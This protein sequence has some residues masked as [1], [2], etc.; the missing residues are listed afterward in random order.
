LSYVSIWKPVHDQIVQASRNAQNE[1]IGLLLGRLDTDT[2]IIEDSIT[3]EFE[4]EKHRAILTS[5]T[6]AR[7]ADDVVNGRVKGSIVGWYHSHTEGGLF[8]SDTDIQTQKNLQQFS[9][10]VTALVADSSNGETGYFRVDTRTGRQLRIPGKNV[11]VFEDP[12]EAVPLDRKEKARVLPT[13]TVEVRA[14]P[15]RPKLPSRNMILA[16]VLVALALSVSLFGLLL[17][18]GFPTVPGLAIGHDPVLTGTIGAPIEIKA[19]VNGTIRSV[20]LFYSVQGTTSF[21]EVAMSS[22]T[23][24]EYSYSIPGG[25]VAGNIVYYIK[26]VDT[27]GSQVQTPKYTIPVADFALPAS[28]LVMTVYR[29][30]ST[31][32]TLSLVYMNGFNNAVSFSA[33][34]APQ[35][36]SVIFTPNPVPSGTAKA[37]MTVAAGPEAANGMFSLLVTAAYTPSQ[38]PPVVRETTAQIVVAAFDLQI[39][40]SSRTISIGG[41]ATYTLTLTITQGFTDPVQVTVQGLPQGARY[42]LVTSGT[43]AIVGGAGTTTLT[44]RII[45]TTSVKSGNYALMVIAVGG[46]LIHH[47]TIQLTVR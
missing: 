28:G 27:L 26:A 25:K 22:S 33:T 41:T 23:T 12:A 1:I 46:G 24:G 13:P 42:E 30:G 5:N 31:S 45:T 39:S 40:P 43:T 15:P 19:I 3:G 2:I 36:V 11:M 32:T 9:S 37:T 8:L 29:N 38:G 10:L 16:I 21:T 35:G 18:R 4:T 47:L 20:S 34:G 44:L 14:L 6:L 7:I 17:F